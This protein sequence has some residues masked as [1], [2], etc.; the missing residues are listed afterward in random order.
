M[1]IDKFQNAGKGFT[2]MEIMIA[3]II[4]GVIASLALP[5]YNNVVRQNECRQAQQ[6]MVLIYN[7]VQVFKIKICQVH[8][9]NHQL[10]AIL[11]PLLTYQ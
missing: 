4:L 10:W 3:V 9:P 8:F 11:I 1:K 6:N 7:T 5:R 2:L